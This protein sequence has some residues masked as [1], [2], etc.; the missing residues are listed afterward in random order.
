[1]TI[2][3]FVM[4]LTIAKRTEPLRTKYSDVSISFCGAVAAARHLYRIPDCPDFVP[5]ISRQCTLCAL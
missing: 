5:L 2:G 1:M 3:I 4:M